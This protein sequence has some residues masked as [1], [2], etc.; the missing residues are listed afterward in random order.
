MRL[1]FFTLLLFFFQSTLAQDTSLISD[2]RPP[3]S[4]SKVNTTVTSILDSNR[5]IDFNKSAEEFI[6]KEKKRQSDEFIFYSIVVLFF[7]FGLLKISYSRY[8]S[9][10]MRVF[11]NTSLRQSQLTDQL[12]QSKL[13]SLFF[14]IFYFI[15]SGFYIYIVL[16]YYG[17]LIAAF[18]YPYYFMIV[19]IVTLIYFAK[20]M[21]VKFTGWISNYNSEAELYIFIVFLVNKIIAVFLLPVIFII[22]FAEPV[23]T[24]PVLLLSYFV[25]GS[26]FIIRYIKSYGLLQNKLNIKRLHFVLYIIAL[27]VIPLFLL[28]KIAERFL[29]NYL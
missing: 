17:Y 24:R 22:A 12:L 25:I 15:V 19:G 10:M 20:Y 5:L 4:I 26:L 8:L 18:D 13:P 14:N 2:I 28:F 6:I 3:D 1:L 11:F 16:N 9:T 27:E 23:I 7:L 21:V 29:T